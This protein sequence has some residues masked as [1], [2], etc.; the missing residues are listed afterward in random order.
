MDQKAQL[1][2]DK[3]S[4]HELSLLEQMLSSYF[5]LNDAE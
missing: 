4:L 5:F 2:E 1:V 3:I